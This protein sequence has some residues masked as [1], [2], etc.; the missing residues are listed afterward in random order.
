MI[1]TWLAAG[2]ALFFLAGGIGAA[3]PARAEEDAL[4]PAQKSAV[5]RLIE[6]YIDQHPE[7]VKKALQKVEER[8]AAAAASEASEAIKAK[9]D[10]LFHDAADLVEGNPAGDV[11]IV[12]F[13]DYRCPY[14][15]RI[16]PTL[17]QALAEDGHIRLV[18]KELPIL[19]P[20]SIV[21]SR[22]AIAARKQGKYET[23]HRVLLDSK[24]TLDDKTI[25]ELA[26]KAGLDAKRL[27]EDMK[28]PAIEQQ[29]RKNL[30]LADSLK[31]D[32]TPALVVGGKVVPGA[33]DH[34]ALAKLVRDAREKS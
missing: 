11:T 30:A 5:E 1:R 28:D 15:K 33:V 12:E 13:F 24:V 19:G 27:V 6:S 31:I 29:I 9:S 20:A 25:L 23:L 21:A 8:E 10:E 17:R 22:A 3:A 26:E 14:C 4:T 34:D 16:S 7:I 32:G 18:L 2:A